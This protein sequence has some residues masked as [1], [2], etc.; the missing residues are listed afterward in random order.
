MPIATARTAS[1]RS[2]SCGSSASTRR[3]AINGVPYSRIMQGLK[4]RWCVDRSQDAG[5]SGRARSGGVCRRCGGREE[6]PSRPGLNPGANSL[7]PSDQKPEIKRIKALRDRRSVRHAERLCIVEGP[8]FVADAARI[9]RP[10]LLV[11][12]SRRADVGTAG[13]WRSPRSSPTSSLPRSLTPRRRKASWAFS[14]SRACVVDR[15]TPLF[16]IADGIQDPG[17]LG[18]MI[19][20][21]AA[22][23]AT[24]VICCAGNR[25]SVRPR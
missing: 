1:G 25:R 18:T 15:L 4:P 7:R 14:V 11:V 10:W 22:L 19:R 13:G 3:P 21:A 8:R 2:G 17:N 5:R 24:G 20:S 23:G 9:D 16:L 12:S 6:E